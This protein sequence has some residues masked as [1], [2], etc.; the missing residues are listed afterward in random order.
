MKYTVVALAGLLV[1]FLLGDYLFWLFAFLL[2]AMAL[3]C[4]Y[5][6][7]I[8]YQ[9]WQMPEEEWQAKTAAETHSS[10]RSKRTKA[11]GFAVIMFI[12]LALIP[13]CLSYQAVNLNDG[14]NSS[15]N[16][17]AANFTASSTTLTGADVSGRGKTNP[18]LY[19]A[20][21]L[22][23]VFLGAASGIASIAFRK[24]LPK[25]AKPAGIGAATFMLLGS[26]ALALNMVGGDTNK[27]ND[28]AAVVAAETTPSKDEGGDAANEDGSAKIS[29]T[30]TQ[31]KVTVI[32]YAKVTQNK[33]AVKKYIERENP[34]AKLEAARG[35]SGLKTAPQNAD[36]AV[37]KRYLF[38]LAKLN[39]GALEPTRIIKGAEETAK[40]YEEFYDSEF[41]LVTEWQ[42]AKQKNT[43][44]DDLRLAELMKR[45]EEAEKEIRRLAEWS[46][47]KFKE[48]H[49]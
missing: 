46:E 8:S 19:L 43:A 41:L 21:G 5:R 11:D 23:F 49:S 28:S 4:L 16:V 17:P 47:A 34:F 30:V 26:G 42:N 1:I 38:L 48:Q 45:H 40:I 10:V 2:G 39:E 35:Q 33:D 31:D 22:G 6:A 37:L 14:G 29:S 12:L 20:A 25:Y 7:I 36:V 13:G 32:D 18:M 44:P 24:R 3:W 27:T 15:S 9:E